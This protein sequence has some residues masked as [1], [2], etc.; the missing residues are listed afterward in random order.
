MLCSLAMPK[1][2]AER[3]RAA[4]ELRGWTQEKAATSIGVHVVTL[5]KWEGGAHEP[6]GLAARAAEKWIAASR[7]GGRRGS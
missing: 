7:K 3:L 2:F 4:R 5:A 1:S 6:K